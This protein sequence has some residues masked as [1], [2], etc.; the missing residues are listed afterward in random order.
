ME[1]STKKKLFHIFM[2]IVIIAILLFVVGMIMLRYQVEGEK[3]LPFDISKITIISSVDSIDNKDEANRWNLS[4]NQNNDMYIYIDKNDNYNKTEIID[5]IVINN[6][7]INKPTEKGAITVYKPTEKGTA[8]FENTEENIST[9]IT[10]LG[11][12]ETSIKNLKISNQGGLI[13]LRFAN[14]NISQYVSNDAQE[15]DYSKLLQLTNVSI[16]DLKANITF[17]LYINLTSGKTFKTEV[18]VE[19]PIESVIENG[20]ASQEN[21][22]TRNL[23]FKRIENN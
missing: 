21:T 22:E 4:V 12:M 13:V 15:V 10:Y 3:N 6:I 11:D 20:T 8:M 9:E 17:D 18:N 14:N 5:S 2:I 19:I 1:Q 23:I 16:E 7:T